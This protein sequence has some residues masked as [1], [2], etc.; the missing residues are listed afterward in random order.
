MPLTTYTAGEVLTAAS[1]N[2][3]LKV[4]GGLQIVKAQTTFTAS[5]SVTVDNVFTSTYT[6]YHLKYINLGF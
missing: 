6:N 4:A 3:N 5:S 1:L 2:S